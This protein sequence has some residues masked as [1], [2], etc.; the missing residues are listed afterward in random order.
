MANNTKEINLHTKQYVQAV[1]EQRLREEGFVCPDEKLLCWYRLKD[2]R[3]VNSIIF[4]SVWSNMPLMLSV[5]YGIH[6][7]FQKPAYTSNVHYQKRPS[8]HELF[9]Q[10]MIVENYPINA[11]AY[12]QYSDDIRVAAPAHDGKGIYTFDSII[13]PKMEVIN[14]IVDC[15]QRHKYDIINS[16]D[17]DYSVKYAIISD[18]FVD[19][20]LYVGDVEVY[21][22]CERSIDKHIAR[23]QKSC[24]EKP[25]E[26]AYQ[27]ELQN[28]ELRKSTL[29]DGTRKEY[30]QILEKRRLDNLAYMKKKRMI[31]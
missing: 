12:T 23:F 28:W 21:P 11:M 2:E 7:L 14:T 25:A 31:V 19:E 3:I 26:R 8:D 6:P 24:K 9:S 30:L 10:Q 4:Y 17:D 18:V 29:L 20:A 13:L 27:V 1:F 15:Y 22:Y 16:M 5:G